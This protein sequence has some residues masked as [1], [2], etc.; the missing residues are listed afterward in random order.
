[1]G[2]VYFTPVYP[3][4]IYQAFAYLKSH[5]KLYKDVSITKGLSSED[6]LRFSVINIEI[7][8]KNDSATEKLF[9]MGKNEGKYE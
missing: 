9:W 5:N 1:M 4:I 3:H 7:Q 6:M 8:G 2:H